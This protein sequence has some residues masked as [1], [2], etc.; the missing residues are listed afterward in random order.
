[1]T[2][3]YAD[4]IVAL[5]TPRGYSGIGVIRMSGPHSIPILRGIFL[6]AGGLGDFPDRVA[7]WGRICDPSSGKIIDDGIS[8]VMRGPRSFTGE[9]VVEIS[10][11]GSPAALDL[12]IERIV[13]LGARLAERGEFTLRA[14]LSGKLD[15]I[16]AE[17]V[18]DLIESVS[19]AAVEDA[20]GRLDRCLSEEVRRVSDA[21]KDLLATVEA[22]I[23][24]DEE[25]ET[26]QPDIEP[27][28]RLIAE[29]MDALIARA[30]QA[31]FKREGLRT[32]IAGKPNV[33]KSTLFNALLRSDRTIVTPYPGTTRD[34]VEDHLVLGGLSFVLSDTAGIRNN[35]EPIEEEGIRRT[36]EAIQAA[37]LLIVVVDLTSPWDAQDATILDLSR[38]KETLVVLNKSDLPPHGEGPEVRLA[39]LDLPGIRLSAKTGEGVDSLRETLAA[40]GTRRSGLHE[41]HPPGG[42]TERAKL[43]MEEARANLEALLNR[44]VSGQGMEPSLSALEL[45]RALGSLEEI[46]GERY[47][48]GVLER[49]FSRFCV[50]K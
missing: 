17:A 14:F 24:F 13:G 33:G 31:R 8:V 41:R 20:R 25:D 40:V 27:E 36:L 50:G 43:L 46:T 32:V 48:E 38:Q 39:A 16:Q 26:P 11:H 4:T 7:V 15:L 47:D 12:T 49:I 35:P 9:D 2:I 6:P 23:D 30:S 1:M 34:M 45:G 21:L 19:P 22:H 28:L 5:S 44:W 42:L 29:R 37:D 10:L 3:R 18:I